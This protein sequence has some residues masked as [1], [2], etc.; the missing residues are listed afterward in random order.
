MPKMLFIALGQG[1]RIPNISH[2]NRV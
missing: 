1:L 2:R